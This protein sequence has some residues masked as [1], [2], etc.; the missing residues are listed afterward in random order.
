MVR[1][2]APFPIPFDRQSSFQFLMVRLKVNSY[3]SKLNKFRFQFLMVRLKVEGSGYNRAI[4][5]FQFL[6]VR[7]K[8]N[9]CSKKSN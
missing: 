8:V 2:K 5:I 4:K 3:N 9:R 6:M 7:L 1:L